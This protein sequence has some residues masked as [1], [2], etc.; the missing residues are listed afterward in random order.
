MTDFSLTT[1]YHHSMNISPTIS[2]T[3]ICPCDPGPSD[4]CIN[5]SSGTAPYAFQWSNGSIQNCNSV[6]PVATTIYS[7]VTT[8]ATGC[9][10]NLQM[11]VKVLNSTTIPEGMTVSSITN[12]TAKV[13]MTTESCYS[14]YKVVYRPLIPGAMSA[15]IFSPALPVTLTGLTCNTLYEVYISAGMCGVY[16]QQAGVIF[17][18]APCLGGTGEDRSA[19]SDTFIS[20]DG[21]IAAY[22]NP[23][24]GYLHL[25]WESIGRLKEIQVISTEGKLISQ[26]YPT[27]ESAIDLDLSAIPGGIYVIK[28]ISETGKFVSVR[29]IKE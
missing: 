8:D 20:T 23:T 6:N 14:D 16:T 11:L 2:Q 10:S 26:L 15:V 21:S 17:K 7:C 19:D 4:L 27:T 22:P 25:D 1:T 5:P 12:T 3:V 13:N 24:T 29:I 18:T 28:G 9:T